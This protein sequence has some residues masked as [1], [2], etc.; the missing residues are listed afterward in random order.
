MGSYRVPSSVGSLS[1]PGN[2]E[3]TANAIELPDG[4]V[5]VGKISFDPKLILGKGCEGTFVYK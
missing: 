3:I 2:H 4:T 1:G 5:Q